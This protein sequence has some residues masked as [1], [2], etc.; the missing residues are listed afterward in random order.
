[1]IILQEPPTY[2]NLIGRVEHIAQLGALVTNF[3]LIKPGAL[4]RANGGYLLLD[5]RKVL[6][7]PFA[8]EGLKRALQ[9]SKIHIESL[10][11]IYSLVSTVSLEPEAIPLDV[12]VVLFGDRLFYYLLQAYDPEFSELFKVAADFEETIERNAESHLLYAQ[13]I[14]TLSRKEGL[15]PYDRYA[16]ARVIEHSARLVGDSEKLS[17]HMRSIADLLR[18]ADYWAREAGQDVVRANDVQQAIDAQVRRQDRIRDRLYEAIM[19]G[20]LMIDTQGGVTGQVNGLSVIE[21]GGFAFAQPTR[22]TAT[23][24]FGKG[25]L[26]NVERE[27]KLSGAIHS[28]GVLI[29]SAFLAARYARNQPL[30]LSASLAFEQTYGMIEGDSASLAELCALL[31]NLA[32]VPINQSLAITGSVNQFGQVQAIGAV[33]E[34]IE[35]FFDIC[36][37]RGMTGT[38]GV[39]IPAANVQHLMLRKN[40]VEAVAAGNF[41][42][43]AV[44]NVDQA[45]ALLTGL[46]AGEVDANDQYPEGSVNYLVATQLTELTKI[47]KS[48]Q[49]GGKN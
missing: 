43:Y 2:S 23:T 20:T 35:G 25:D 24:R 44:E 18:E 46:P 48:L 34:K 29:L 31:S 5:V 12:K 10:G 3:M 11:Q 33:N 7:Q 17:M 14:S 1:V 39:L 41:R 13:L 32:M 28:K 45:I 30:A 27:V 38:Q 19:R 21:L 4:H 40:V 8:W 6:L 37:A 9:S 49:Q 22:I 36:A 47:S 42:I 16:V 15:L 26:I